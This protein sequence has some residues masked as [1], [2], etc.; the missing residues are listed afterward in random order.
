M[1]SRIFPSDREALLFRFDEIV[2]LVSRLLDAELADLG[3]NRAQWKLLAFVLRGDGLTQSELAR[4]LDL[5]RATVGQAIDTMERKGLLRREPAVDDRRVWRIVATPQAQELL[6]R[7]A[8]VTDSLIARLFT[9][10]G[11]RDIS[12]LRDLTN[13]LADNL[14]AP[15]AKS[16]PLSALIK[17]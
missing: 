3:L 15:A 17:A 2:R 9:G 8:P 1:T 13:R 6:P 10:L 16:P 4:L 7:L 14:G 12:D 5:E 11:D